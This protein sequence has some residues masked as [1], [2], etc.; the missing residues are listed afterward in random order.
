M[1]FRIS[2]LNPHLARRCLVEQCAE[3][4]QAPPPYRVDT[5][6]SNLTASILRLD[7]F[8]LDLGNYS[9]STWW[10]IVEFLEKHVPINLV[11]AEG[12]KLRSDLETV[13]RFSR[14][15]LNANRV[16]VSLRNWFA[17]GDLVWHV[18]R[19]TKPNALRILWPLERRAGMYVTPVGN[20]SVNQYRA[21]MQR[22]HPLLCRLDRQIY[23]E[24]SS[25]DRVWKHRPKQVESMK[26]GEFEFLANNKK[27]FQLD[28]EG[29]SIHRIESPS[30]PGTWHHSAWENHKTPGIQVIITA[31][32]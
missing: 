5:R 29:V 2:E 23:E 21:Y 11:R 13:V 19:S 16:L 4:V 15:V 7:P 28:P 24:R 20:I 32:S 30:W 26:T 8:M 1:I 17:P 22:E 25:L 9:V 3:V 31:T 27:V 12:N 10:Q 18:D 6:Y 14:L